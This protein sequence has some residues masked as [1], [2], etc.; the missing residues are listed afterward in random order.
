[1]QC[2]SVVL[3]QG[4]A[5]YLPRI[6]LTKQKEYQRYFHH[7]IES[8]VYTF[9]VYAMEYPHRNT[10][11]KL[12]KSSKG[13]RGEKSAQVGRNMSAAASSASSTSALASMGDLTLS[14]QGKRRPKLPRACN[15][16]R[17]SE[18]GVSQQPEPLDRMPS[19]TAVEREEEER[20]VMAKKETLDAWSQSAATALHFKNDV[21]HHTMCA[22]LANSACYM[23]WVT[24]GLLRL[25]DLLRLYCGLA[26]HFDGKVIPHAEQDRQAAQKNRDTLVDRLG[27]LHRLYD[28]PGQSPRDFEAELKADLKAAWIWALSVSMSG[29]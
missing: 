22:E 28:G 1:M 20:R 4:T 10:P 15:T 29:L 7:Q 14:E 27:Q 12:V 19:V 17:V 26:F 8:L 11:I 23:A 21:A 2:R 3:S 6:L 18:T 24:D 16:G 13:G 5:L 25:I 9:L